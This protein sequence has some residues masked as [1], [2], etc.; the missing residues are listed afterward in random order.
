VSDLLIKDLF[1]RP[2]QVFGP[3]VQVFFTYGL[4]VLVACGMG[5]FAFLGERWL[6][7]TQKRFLWAVP[8]PVLLAGLVYGV[9]RFSGCLLYAA[10]GW[11]PSGP[12]NYTNRNEGALVLAVCGCLLTGAALALWREW[13]ST[14]Y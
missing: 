12:W 1:L 11:D 10:D 14:R 2:V 6:C 3:V 7:R 5:G 13:R 4:L 8:V 9:L